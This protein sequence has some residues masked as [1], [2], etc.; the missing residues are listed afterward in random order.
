[1]R[2]VC[3]ICGCTDARACPGG[4]SWVN[5]EHTLCSSCLDFPSG[6]F[7]CM[8]SV[9]PSGRLGLNDSGQGLPGKG[10]PARVCGEPDRRLA[11]LPLYKERHHLSW[12][13]L[14]GRASN[15]HAVWAPLE[16]EV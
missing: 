12:C 3:D 16:G 11:W 13:W 10:R 4:C 2:G 14:P 1:M 8:G 6:H 5:K 15:T 7:V 9:H